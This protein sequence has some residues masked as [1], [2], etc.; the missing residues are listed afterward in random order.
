MKMH[1]VLY[2]SE[3]DFHKKLE[4][5]GLSGGTASSPFGNIAVR[6]CGDYICALGFHQSDS[7]LNDLYSLPYQQDSDVAQKVVDSILKEEPLSLLLAGTPFQHHV[8]KALL[9]I[10]KGKVR[11]YEDIAIELGDAKKCRAVGSAVGKNPLS[12]IIPCHRVL[13]K[14]GGIGNYYWGSELKEQLLKSEDYEP[15]K[16]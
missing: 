10:P 7:K 11:F 15:T 13:P 9:K 6:K 1:T 14:Q 12:W 5:S 4:T 8:W 2:L 16:Y 3:A